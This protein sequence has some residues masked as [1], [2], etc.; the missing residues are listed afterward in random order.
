MVD[1]HEIALA[2]REIP[3]TPE[4]R[5]AREHLGRQWQQWFLLDLLA[6]FCEVLEEAV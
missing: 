6:T 1:T 2:L 4:I 3:D 5:S